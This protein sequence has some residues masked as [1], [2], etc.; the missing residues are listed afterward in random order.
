MRTLHQFNSI[1]FLLLLSSFFT[2]MAIAQPSNDS[3]CN[4]TIL[5]LDAPC[6]MANGDLTAASLE[7][8]EPLGS[9]FYGIPSQASVWYQ[10]TA[11]ENGLVLISANFPGVGT[12]IDLQMALYEL[13]GENCSFDGLVEVACNDA[14]VPTTAIEVLPT[15]SA[16]LMEG[17][18]YYIQIVEQ[19]FD[20]VQAGTF[21]VQVASVAAPVNDD[22]C[23]A[24]ALDLDSAPI[25]FSNIGA[26]SIDEFMF[27]PPFTP[28][29]FLGFS[30]WGINVEIS[31]SIWFSFVA[32]ET[33]TVEIDLL[34]LDIIGNYNSKIAVYE[35]NAC[36]EVSSANLVAAQAAT[37]LPSGGFFQIFFLNRMSQLSCLTPGQTY[38]ILVDG[39]ND[40]FGTPTNAIGKGK[41]AINTIDLEAPDQILNIEEVAIFPAGCS[42]DA[43]GAINVIP[44]GGAISNDAADGFGSPTYNFQWSHSEEVTS[45]YVEGL[46]E[47]VYEVTVSDLCGNEQVSTF[48]VTAFEPPIVE[49]SEDTLVVPGEPVQLF[50]YA[51]GG[52][53]YDE[54]RLFFSTGNSRIP[55]MGNVSV[56]NLYTYEETTALADST[57]PNY[58]RITYLKAD[59]LVGVEATFSIA[60]GILYHFNITTGESELIDTLRPLDEGERIKDIQYNPETGEL[61]ALNAFYD[62]NLEED[63]L[64][65]YT[66]DMATAAMNLISTIELGGFQQNTGFI[67]LE[68]R[69]IL[70]KNGDA[71]LS[72]LELLEVELNTGTV[73]LFESI[74]SFNQLQTIMAYDIAS[75]DLIFSNVEPSNRVNSFYRFNLDYRILEPLRAFSLDEFS[76]FDFTFSP[77]TV[78]AY[79]YLWTSTSKLDDPFIPNPT[80]RVSELTAFASAAIDACGEWGTD[81]AVIDI[82]NSG[83]G[84]DLEL[85]LSTNSETYTTFQTLTYRISLT[86][87][88]PQAATNIEIEAKVPEMQ[89]YTKH[90]ITNGV[91]RSY[92]GIWSIGTLASGATATLELT[93]FPLTRA[94]D[95]SYFTQVIASDIADPDSTP[96]NSSSGVAEEDDEASIVLSNDAMTRSNPIPTLLQAAIYPVPAMDKL[97]L[98][99]ESA[100]DA[101]AILSVVN[102]QGQV[103]FTERVMINE[104]YNQN[105]L[106]I[107][108]LPAGNYAIKIKGMQQA[109]PFTKISN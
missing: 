84:S 53:P 24:I 71:N 4:A 81:F 56:M 40:F 77:R 89:P 47:G 75:N 64:R 109:I 16:E 58:N 21:C 83:E 66:V 98:T 90:E 104:G 31:H 11:P 38:Y 54:D 49:V 96:D 39:S 35:A 67:I 65:F 57:L 99:F 2:T 79:D 20:E 14:E 22:I 48:E 28:S 93:L 74:A 37:S 102:M 36:T 44:K 87:F 51:V 94:G 50:N 106:N 29:D 85:S 15:I 6:D 25:E 63:V 100:S 30:S 17:Q 1:L 70:L 60:A 101:D 107:A 91:Y 95:I 68:G 82:D 62:E 32:P 97:N 45:G 19:S 23:D 103:V 78:E 88:G 7:T 76:F 80:A 10:F 42:G 52:V 73:R 27:A 18:V 59:E 41:I 105:N 69:K 8:D 46:A 43:F 12:A 26:T 86:N 9:C 72:S 5:T 34:N 13:S 108:A 33:G 61:L 55:N 92:P 3:F